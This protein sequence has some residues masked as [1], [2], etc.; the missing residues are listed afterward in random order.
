[1]A[2]LS[3]RVKKDRQTA[4]LCHD[5]FVVHTTFSSLDCCVLCP[6][7]LTSLLVL[8]EMRASREKVERTIPTPSGFTDH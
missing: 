8:E 1:M 7:C 2:N 5:M 4:G 3:D 6:A